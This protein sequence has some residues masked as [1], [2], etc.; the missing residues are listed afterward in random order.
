M[1]VHFAYGSTDFAP[2]FALSLRLEETIT[3]AAAGKFDGNELAADGSDGSLYMYGPDAG[4]LF[5]VVRPVLE[6]AARRA[7]KWPF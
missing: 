5:G 1:I 2:V 6:S 7:R 4:R 3:A